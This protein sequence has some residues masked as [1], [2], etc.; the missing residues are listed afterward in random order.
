MR[1]ANVAQ[2]ERVMEQMVGLRT[3]GELADRTGLSF[4]QTESAVRILAYKGMIERRNGYR[5]TARRC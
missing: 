2:V 3:V 5:W 1:F 4:R